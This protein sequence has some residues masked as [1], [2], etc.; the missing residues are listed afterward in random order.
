[1][2]VGSGRGALIILEGL[3]RSGKTTQCKKLLESLRS[4]Q[5][6]VKLIKFPDRTTETGKM[7]DSYLKQNM[8]IDDRAIHLLFSANRWEKRLEMLKDLE[9]GITLI[10]DRYAFSGVAFSSAKKGLELEWCKCPDRGLPKPDLVIFLN[11]SSSDAASRGGYGEERYENTEF[12]KTVAN[13]F[14]RMWD[15]WKVIDAG[16]S[17]DDVHQTILNYVKSTMQSVDDKPIGEL[18]IR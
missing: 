18:W 10:V 7:I 16:G 4:H 5:H 12:Q 15:E 6:K 9:Q 2:A 1:M 11:V 17:I 14:K 3:D 13:N 8:K